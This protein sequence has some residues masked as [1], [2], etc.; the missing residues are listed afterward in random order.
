MHCWDQ[1]GPVPLDE[2]KQLGI[3]NARSTDEI[4]A[5]RRVLAE[6]F[7]CMD[8]GHYNKRLC[9]EIERCEAISSKRTDAG[10]AG[11]LER[12]R[13]LREAQASAKQ[14][15]SNCL[16][17]ASESEANAKH[18]TLSPSP[19]PSL[20]Q[21]P[22]SPYD[23]SHRTADLVGTAEKSAAP[24]KRGSRLQDDWTLPADWLEWSLAELPA[25]TEAHARAQAD[26]FRDYWIS[27][28]G[29]A[30]CKVRWEATWRNWC[31]SDLAQPGRVNGNG[32]GHGAAA[33]PAWRT[34]QRELAAAYLGRSAR[35]PSQQ[36]AEV[37]DVDAKILG[38]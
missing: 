24:S 5:M 18:V 11:A 29:K 6:F 12:M 4:E 30:G 27:V 1:R 22:P 15:P 2:R 35:K 7:V 21:A 16:A 13:K 8:D 20:S 36:K 33:E 25:W 19:S 23:N 37:I 3:V 14:V 38:C 31:R 26:R 17:S 10:R 34:E 32:N 28:P 9:R